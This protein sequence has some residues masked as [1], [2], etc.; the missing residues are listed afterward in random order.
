VISGTCYGEEHTT[1]RPIPSGLSPVG[2]ACAMQEH[3]RCRP[4]RTGVDRLPR[5]GVPSY[6]RVVGTANTSGW[7]RGNPG[8]VCMHTHS[9][10][11]P[12]R[13][14]GPDVQ[15][16]GQHLVEV[17]RCGWGARRWRQSGLPLRLVLHGQM[18][19]SVASPLRQAAWSLLP[20]EPSRRQPCHGLRSRTAPTLIRP[21]ASLPERC[22]A[23]DPTRPASLEAAGY[24]EAAGEATRDPLPGTH[25]T[26]TV[27]RYM[28]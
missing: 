16:N 9:R 27:D 6:T 24:T 13:E 14:G 2:H 1:R 8:A 26:L 18:G 20:R 15:R 11:K 22:E 17:S 7:Q 5:H 19:S 28:E 25:P 21:H 23:A 10:D 12:I 4:P 3:A